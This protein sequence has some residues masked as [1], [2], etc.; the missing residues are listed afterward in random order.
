NRLVRVTSPAGTWIYEYDALGNRAASTHNGQRTEYLVDPFGLGDVT[1]EY[2]GTGKL[3]AHYTDGIDLTSRV[4]ASGVA[5]YY[6]FDALGSTVGLS[7]AAGSYVD[8]Y[9]YLPFGESLASTGP[10]AQPFQFVGEW[11]VMNDGNGVDYMRA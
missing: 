7:G 3:V 4:D 1:A 6:D 9:S 11:G 2:D 8:T 10:I 5:S